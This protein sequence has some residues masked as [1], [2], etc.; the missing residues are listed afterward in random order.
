MRGSNS[1]PESIAL[2]DA[3]HEVESLLRV[4]V[5]RWVSRSSTHTP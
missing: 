4:V 1:Y 2:K 5:G 3:E